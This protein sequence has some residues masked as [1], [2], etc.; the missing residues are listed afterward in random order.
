MA[1]SL[2]IESETPPYCGGAAELIR[3]MGMR[4]RAGR[5]PRSSNHQPRRSDEESGSFPGSAGSGKFL[6]HVDRELQ[7]FRDRVASLE[8]KASRA[9]ISDGGDLMIA[10]ELLHRETL[11]LRAEIREFLAM[12]GRSAEMMIDHV[13]GTWQQL[14]ESFDELEENL[15]P[16]PPI[17]VL[18]TS[19]ND[20][21]GEEESFDES[22]NWNEDEPEID[23]ATEPHQEVHP[24]RIGPK[25]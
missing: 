24:P 23:L 1:L 20:D 14:R 12:G 6:K 11:L 21:D 9:E 22:L 4:R 3:S 7:L 15:A 8:E 5:S 25:W 13:E 19:E 10:V 18:P 17:T 2:L 16:W